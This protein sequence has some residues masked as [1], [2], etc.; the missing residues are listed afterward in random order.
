MNNQLTNF[1][2]QEILNEAKKRIEKDK[3]LCL[4]KDLSIRIQDGE[5]KSDWHDLGAGTGVICD[6]DGCTSLFY[7]DNDY[8]YSVDLKTAILHNAKEEEALPKPLNNR[9]IIQKTYSL[10]KHLKTIL[11]KG[12]LTDAL[13]RDSLKDD[14]RTGYQTYGNDI[15]TSLLRQG[16]TDADHDFLHN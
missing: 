15:D 1:T 8:L 11:A 7:Q 10:E 2:D 6:A 12:G 5:I 4:L 9:Q 16:F 3:I 14:C 13:S